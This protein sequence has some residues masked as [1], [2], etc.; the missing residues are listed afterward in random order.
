MLS[1]RFWDDPHA[2]LRRKQISARL[3][4]AASLAV[5]VGFCAVGLAGLWEMR[6]ADWEQARTNATNLVSTLEADIAR[7]LQLYDLSLQAVVDG[8]N[9]PDLGRVSERIRRLVLFDRSATA[10]H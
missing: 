1:A 10:K 4:L 6:R 5:M 3:L 7:N 2:R 9:E 8:L